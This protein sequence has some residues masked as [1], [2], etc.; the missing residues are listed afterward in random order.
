M[1]SNVIDMNYFGLRN[2]SDA[3]WRAFL[4]TLPDGAADVE[5]PPIDRFFSFFFCSRNDF[6]GVGAGAACI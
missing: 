2:G 6:G 4:G 1:I 5:S 3:S